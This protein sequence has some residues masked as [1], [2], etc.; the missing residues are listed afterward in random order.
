MGFQYGANDLRV[1][2]DGMIKEVNEM[3]RSSGIL[4]S[5][6]NAIMDN[7]SWAG[8][9]ADKYKEY[10]GFLYAYILDGTGKLCHWLNNCIKIY[11]MSYTGYVDP[12]TNAIIY[13][14]EVDRFQEGLMG[15]DTSAITIQDEI[16]E[17]IRIVNKFASVIG[18]SDPGVVDSYKAIEK[19]IQD[20]YSRVDIAE[21]AI[22]DLMTVFDKECAAV[23]ALIDTGLSSVVSQDKRSLQIDKLSFDAAIAQIKNCNDEYE[24]E[25]KENLKHFSL[26]ERFEE[27]KEVERSGKHADAVKTIIDIL[28]DMGKFAISWVSGPITSIIGSGLIGFQQEAANE[29]VDQY[30]ETGEIHIGEVLLQGLNGG[31]EELGW[32]GVGEVV[33]I[34]ISFMMSVVGSPYGEAVLG[35]FGSELLG[36]M[37]DEVIPDFIGDMGAWFGEIIYHGEQG[38]NEEHDDC[39]NEPF[40]SPDDIQ[41]VLEEII[42]NSN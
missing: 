23:N 34:G 19:E 5:N 11:Y 30:A 9:T 26:A 15:Y 25:R 36:E 4:S 39:D 22:E 33:T 31:F 16:K 6:A 1:L 13:Q 35:S 2:K 42:E 38:D 28:G 41:I 8:R 27:E 29:A 14:D 7:E 21:K 18:I 3:N 32:S 20:M 10:I 40:V 37:W 12:D 24:T 17:Q